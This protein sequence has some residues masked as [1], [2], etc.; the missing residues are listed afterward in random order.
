MVKEG[1]T[2]GKAKPASG[3]WRSGGARRFVF[4]AALYTLSKGESVEI[5]IEVLGPSEKPQTLLARNQAVVTGKGGQGATD[6][7]TRLALTFPCPPFTALSFGFFFLLSLERKESSM[8]DFP[9]CPFPL[10]VGFCSISSLI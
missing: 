4:P 2:L 6:V 5:Q 3:T 9:P 10:S 7:G 8:A 1:Q